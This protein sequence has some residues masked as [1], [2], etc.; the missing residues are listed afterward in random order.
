MK[1]GHTED[2]GVEPLRTTGTSSVSRLKAQVQPWTCFRCGTTGGGRFATVSVSMHGEEVQVRMCRSCKWTAPSVFVEGAR[3]PLDPR[4][5]TAMAVVV[6]QLLK[7][8]AHSG[9]VAPDAPISEAEDELGDRLTNELMN[10]WNGYGEYA[11]REGP[12]SR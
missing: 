3:P 9:G 11:P 8:R 7:Q 12:L 1:R 4:Y 5:A 6:P 2:A 10:K